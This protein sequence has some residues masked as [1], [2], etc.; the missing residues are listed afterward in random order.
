MQPV[1][2]VR[3]NHTR[4]LHRPISFLSIP[5]K[6]CTHSRPRAA[7]RLRRATLLPPSEGPPEATRSVGGD[8]LGLP[9]APRNPWQAFGLNWTALGLTS[10]SR[11]ENLTWRDFV[12]F[13]QRGIC[14]GD[15][16]LLNP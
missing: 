3:E 8:S 14:R 9:A 15:R 1:L 13:H 2:M 7:L 5:G 16:S 11:C 10:G 4:F 12:L 6:K